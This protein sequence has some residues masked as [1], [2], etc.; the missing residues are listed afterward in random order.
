VYR[1]SWSQHDVPTL[2]GKDGH[3]PDAKSRKRESHWRPDASCESLAMA[4]PL[5]HDV[6]LR[7]FAHDMEQRNWSYSLEGVLR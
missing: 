6:R 4:M 2:T 3:P 1:Q 5:E 7:I